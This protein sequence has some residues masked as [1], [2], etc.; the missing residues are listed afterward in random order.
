MKEVLQQSVFC[1]MLN[2]L[3]PVVLNSSSELIPDFI[4]IHVTLPNFKKVSPPAYDKV[5]TQI[6]T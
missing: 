4:A 2:F 5:L 1:I 6:V 3:L